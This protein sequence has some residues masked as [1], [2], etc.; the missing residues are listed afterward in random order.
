MKLNCSLYYYKGLIVFILVVTSLALF[1]LEVEV[2][3]AATRVFYDDFESGNTS[4]WS[5]GGSNDKCT[6]VSTAID[7]NSPH[8]GSHMMQCNWNGTVAWNDPASYSSAVLG[9]WSYTNEFLIRMW[10]R[11]DNDVDHKFG[12]KWIRITG[13]YPTNS[14]IADG[15]MEQAGGPIYTNIECLD[16]TCNNWYNYGSGLIG[17]TQWH[18]LEF[19]SKGGSGSIFRIW[20]DDNLEWEKTGFSSSQK[21][22]ELN[23]MSNWSDNGPE[24][25]HD[26]NNH[27]YWDNF[28]IY[29]D[30]TSG[31]PA[32][33][34]TLANGDIAVS[35]TPDTQPPTSPTSLSAS[36]PSQSSITV[37]W[38][39][40]TDNVGVVRYD[41]ERCTGLSCSTFA[42]V[43]TASNSPFTDTGLTASTGY[44]YHVRAVD[45][46]G[47][48]SG[49]SNVVGATTQAPDTTSPSTPTTL[50]ASASSSSTINLTWTASTDNVGVTGYKVE[51]CSGSSCVAFSQIGTSATNSYSDSGLSSATTY[52]YQ[53]RATDAAGNNSSYSSIAQ[54]TTQTPPPVSDSLMLGLSFNEGA[55]STTQDISGHDNTGTLQNGTTWNTTGK[56]GNSLTFD[57]SSSFVAIQDSNA[58]DLTNSMTISAWIY[59]TSLSAG[60]NTILAK[61]DGSSV[62]YDLIANDDTNVPQIYLG[63]STYLR[64]TNQPP[65]N[66]WS[67]IAATFDG[68]TIKLYVNGVLI[69][70]SSFSGTLSASSNQLTIGKSPWGEYFQGRIDDVRIYNVVLS[71]S[72]IQT[73]M[74]T[75]L[76]TGGGSSTPQP[77]STVTPTNFT[78]PTFTGYGAPY[79]V[80]ASNTPLISTQCSSTDTHTLTATLGIPGDTTR[81]VYTKGYYYDP[82][83]NDWT[84]FTG[85]CTGALNGEW[86]QGS[87]SA[88]V[89]NANISTASVSDPSYLV[90]FTCRSQNGSW[91]CGCR[92]TSCSN[93]YWQ[94]Q[95]AGM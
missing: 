4:Q 71:Q 19:Y 93:F 92:D 27:I 95:G 41:I 78:D 6:N 8:E 55:G 88:S 32:T 36:S 10:V 84:S 65:L 85:T 30:S 21:W 26:A 54:A 42:Q 91:K 18:K 53:V 31:T 60:I 12:S 16:G 87:V 5:Q 29:S 62:S 79:D 44:S 58:L 22:N 68:S 25:A 39:A 9:S 72:E 83:I 34:G 75:P 49:W 74:N 7:G 37:S 50:Q 15:Q 2:A 14:F 57:G 20:V 64:G 3:S 63:G 45:A 51:R 82:G 46:A 1:N 76:T 59:P 94:V 89:T 13:N 43:G 11:A 61:E 73:D 24:W 80:F 33:S 90:G 66:T 40:A 35:G 48:V 70:S 28:E 77:C 56:Y 23:I 86:C 38:T 69:S 81:I 17:N 67:Y 47:N 52:R